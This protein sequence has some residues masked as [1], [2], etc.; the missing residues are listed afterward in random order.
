MAQGSCRAIRLARLTLD[1]MTI[2]RLTRRAPAAIINF[3]VP[4]MGDATWL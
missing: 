3:F 4:K 1:P 2:E